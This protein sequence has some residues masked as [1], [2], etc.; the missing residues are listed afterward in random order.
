MSAIKTVVKI[1][2]LGE[3]MEA[4]APLSYCIKQVKKENLHMQQQIKFY[5]FLSKDT[6]RNVY[7]SFGIEK[8][9]NKKEK[10]LKLETIL[11]H[12]KS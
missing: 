5:F 12:A 4:T 6:N 11:L 8:H 9:S 2:Q 3:I 1:L 10:N 7:N